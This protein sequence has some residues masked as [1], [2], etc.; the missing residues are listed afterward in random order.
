MKSKKSIG[1][2]DKRST[3]YGTNS[4][5]LIVAVLG[6]LILVNYIAQKEV[7]RVDV[8]KNK[9]Y[10]LSDQTKNVLD[11]VDE[12]IKIIAFY[13]DSTGAKQEVQ[14]L[15]EEY[16]A[17]NSN[18]T[19]EFIDP[20]K[21]PGTARQYGISRYNAIIIEK[22]DKSEELSSATESELTSGILRLV[23]DDTK[24]VYFL[25]GHGDKSVTSTEQ[26]K[27]YGMIKNELE[28][29]IYTVEELSIISTQGI[30][31]DAAVVILAGPTV[32]ISDKEKEVMRDYIVNRKGKVLFLFDPLIDT[33]AGLNMGDFLNEFGLAYKDGVVIDQA[34]GYYGDALTPVVQKDGFESHQITQKQELVYF[35]G[36]SNAGKAES[37][38]EGW[39]VTELARSTATSWLESD[40]TKTEVGF[41]EGDIEG[42]VSL[43]AVAQEVVPTDQK[44][45]EESS[46]DKDSAR[47]VLVGDS[48]FALD[49]IIGSDIGL[50]NRDLFLNMVNWL[51]ADEDLISI[52]PKEAVTSEVALTGTQSKVIFCLIVF[53]MPAIFVV[54]GIVVIVRRKRKSNKE[55]A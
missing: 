46:D 14:D 45:G 34:Q 37:V 55:H 51:T 1:F 11:Q 38:P 10:T 6:I 41:G 21:N 26:T 22:G 29:Q 17:L 53:G 31:E 43:I 4:I 40:T 44:E 49:A 5:L 33:S 30:P 16:K 42:P 52:L 50:F 3:Q 12:E 35:P 39:A 20:D 24:K 28:K 23:K 32:E 7:Y 15:V 54:V 27:A 47:I 13:T 18:I 2:F 19:L 9:Q 25:T 36:V 48:D 8:T